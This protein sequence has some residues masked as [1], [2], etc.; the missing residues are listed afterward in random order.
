MFIF[1][2]IQNK[3]FF[4]LFI[5]LK[6]PFLKMSC[7]LKDLNPLIIAAKDSLK[8]NSASVSNNNKLI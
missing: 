5:Y 4:Y 7:P 8:K 1:T 6:H 3:S 2:Q